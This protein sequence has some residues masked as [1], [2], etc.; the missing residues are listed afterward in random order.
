MVCSS[1]SK[2]FTNWR[3]SVHRL[4][5]VRKG[6]RM[7]FT[8]APQVEELRP[9][10]RALPKT[11]SR[12][13]PAPR[14][15]LGTKLTDIEDV[16]LEIRAVLSEKMLDLTLS[17]ACRGRPEFPTVSPL[18]GSVMNR[19]PATPPTRASCKRAG[20]RNV[21]AEGYRDRCRRAFFSLSP[22]T[23]IDQ[24]EASPRCSRRSPTPAR[25][26][27]RRGQYHVAPLA[28]I[29]PWAASKSNASPN[30]SAPNG[31]PSR[32]GAQVA[33]FQATPG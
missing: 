12:S 31:S 3:K 17:Q 4:T 25:P 2:V 20:E 30:G 21:R 19:S 13:S 14:S 27:L 18:P 28:G 33:A 24:F 5:Q 22:G 10:S 16:L 6:A 32:D 29:W 1:P 15:C 9:M 23:G 7:A 8:A 26:V 11:W